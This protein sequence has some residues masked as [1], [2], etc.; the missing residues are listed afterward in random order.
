MA[1]VREGECIRCGDCCTGSPYPEREPVEGMCPNLKAQPDG[2]RGCAVHGGSD[3][4]WLAACRHWPSK[5]EHVAHLPRC[6]FTFRE[7]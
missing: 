5:P 4:Y 2:T 6:T 7:G 3:P 1:W